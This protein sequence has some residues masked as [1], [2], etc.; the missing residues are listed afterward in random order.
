MKLSVSFGKEFIT[1]KTSATLIALILTGNGHLM[2]LWKAGC[3]AGITSPFHLPGGYNP[4]AG[5]VTDPAGPIDPNAASEQVEFNH[6]IGELYGGG[7]IV[8]VWKEDG[9]EKGLIASLTDLSAGI[10]WSNLDAA[11]IGPTS[12]DPK[13]GRRNTAAIVGQPDHSSSAA[14]LCDDYIAGGFSDWYLP[15]SWELNLCYN[16]ASEVNGK[17]DP[18]KG[19][20]YAY[21]WSSSEKSADEAWAEL[22]FSGDVGNIDSYK[23]S[24]TF[25]VRAVRRF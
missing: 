18:E 16:S 10:S 24:S 22:F 7:I 1:K 15:A 23:K 9:V 19:F 6:V 17:L 2:A 14:K 13:D 5:S 4:A 25:R 12:Q 3:D 20:Q 21:Y 11:L 8:A